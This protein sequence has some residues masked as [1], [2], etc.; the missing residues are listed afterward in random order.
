[1][2][3]TH[4]GSFHIL[5]ELLMLTSIWSSHVLE[6]KVHSPKQTLRDSIS[7][8][9]E[10]TSIIEPRMVFSLFPSKGRGD[11]GTPGVIPSC[12]PNCRNGKKALCFTG[13]GWMTCFCDCVPPNDS[14][15]PVGR[16]ACA[17]GVH[18][19]T[20]STSAMCLCTCDS[21]GVKTG[22]G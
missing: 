5:V 13:P 19:K 22:S 2:T 11:R 10:S 20:K 9:H 1:M 15:P 6:S 3:S 4:F 16:N 7:T 12:K 8:W 14:C 17:T 21:S 18:F